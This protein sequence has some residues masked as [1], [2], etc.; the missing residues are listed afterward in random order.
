MTKPIVALPNMVHTNRLRVAVPFLPFHIQLSHHVLD[1]IGS[2]A[3]FMLC[4]LRTF[5]LSPIQIG[6]RIGLSPRQT[7]KIISRLSQ[8]RLLTAT[9][10]LSPL[11]HRL[12][13]AIQENLYHNKK[14]VWVDALAGTQTE[15]LM[16]P[17]TVAKPWLSA[18]PKNAVVM[19]NVSVSPQKVTDQL[20]KVKNGHVD[21]FSDLR[22]NLW[23]ETQP[24]FA[25]EKS[26]T[27]WWFDVSAANSDTEDVRYLICDIPMAELT[28]H[29]TPQPAS[30]KTA[31]QIT[32]PVL[33]WHTT[34]HL[35]D[36]I[37]T[38]TPEAFYAEWCLV[39]K[40][41][42]EHIANTVGDEAVNLADYGINLLQAASEFD[43]AWPPM[44]AYL[45]RDTQ[46]SGRLRYASVESTWL[47]QQWVQQYPNLPRL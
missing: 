36:G 47:R 35:P 13:F 39:T 46:L 34:F 38:E 42:L 9:H 6:E 25:Q 29:I 20:S 14:T 2:I 45:N 5:P 44:P 26:N 23:P 40:Q 32:L 33:V 22:Q 37:H 28:C 17:A 8:F 11:G 41:R 3:Q 16:M 31:A 1:N 30:V 18:C 43:P 19:P 4:A 27:D 12:A 21:V 10:T 15:R 24:F 7:D